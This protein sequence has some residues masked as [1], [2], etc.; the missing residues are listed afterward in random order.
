MDEKKAPR[1]TLK[2]PFAGRTVKILALSSDQMV[3]VSML[4]TREP[5]RTLRTFMRLLENQVS[6]S[7]WDEILADQVCGRATASDLMTLLVKL[8]EGSAAALK[9]AETTTVDLPEAAPSQYAAMAE[10]LSVG[11]DA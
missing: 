7:E 10:G 6:A 4:D 5:L 11:V 1:V 2:I 9:A 3:A 8:S